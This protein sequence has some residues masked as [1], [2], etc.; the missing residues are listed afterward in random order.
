MKDIEKI[1]KVLEAK[2]I[3]P[4]KAE[5]LLG[6]AQGA[7]TKSWK[8]R[9][10]V[11]DST[12]EK[13]TRYFNVSRIWWETQTGDMFGTPVKETESFGSGVADL[14]AQFNETLEGFRADIERLKAEKRELEERLRE[15]RKN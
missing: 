7:L 8:R 11:H 4:T 2:Q 10:N 9:G 5:R 14:I 6:L 15:S 1:Y 13:F 3:N 12:G